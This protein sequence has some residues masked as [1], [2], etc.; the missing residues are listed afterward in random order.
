MTP[1]K[2]DEKLLENFLGNRT[3]VFPAR[4]SLFIKPGNDKE[5]EIDLASFRLDTKLLMIGTAGIYSILIQ[6]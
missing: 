1:Q 2:D 3:R 5:D 4:P 6:F